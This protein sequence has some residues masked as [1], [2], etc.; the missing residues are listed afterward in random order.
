MPCQFPLGRAILPNVKSVADHSIQT[1]NLPIMK[2]KIMTILACRHDA[3]KKCIAVANFYC[4]QFYVT[5]FSAD[6]TAPFVLSCGSTQPSQKLLSLARIQYLPA[7]SP[8][9]HAYESRHPSL[10]CK[11]RTSTGR[12][13]RTTDTTRSAATRRRMPCKKPLSIYHLFIVKSL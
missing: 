11:S 3:I 9:R 12:P 4:F 6:R 8:C 10:C 1:T 5:L 7:R 13:V 2:Q